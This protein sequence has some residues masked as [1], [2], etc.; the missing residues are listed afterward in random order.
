MASGESVSTVARMDY[1]QFLFSVCPPGEVS[2][3]SGFLFGPEAVDYERFFS[4]WLPPLSQIMW[5]VLG[6]RKTERHLKIQTYFFRWL[7]T[8]TCSSALPS[9]RA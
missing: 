1:D 9:K 7:T 8:F 2:L 3:G 5:Q 4:K 6:P